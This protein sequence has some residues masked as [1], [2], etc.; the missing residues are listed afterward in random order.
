[1]RLSLG[2]G[3]FLA[4]VL[5]AC[6]TR[7]YSVSH[8]SDRA[9]YRNPAAINPHDMDVSS[10]QATDSSSKK[11]VLSGTKAWKE[12]GSVA[13]RLGHFIAKSLSGES[14]K[15]CDVFH[16]IALTFAAE[17][18]ATSG[19][20]PTMLIESACVASKDG[21]TTETI[22]IPV[23]QIK[24]EKP[25]DSEL[26]FTTPTDVV[27]KLKDIPGEWPTYWVLKEIKLIDKKE[28]RSMTIDTPTIYRLSQIPISISWN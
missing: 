5:G 12:N 4:V 3:V 14:S 19:A 26:R 2:F 7:F 1:M 13:I 11:R 9:G 20:R 6:L 28:G 27:V 21:N 25:A 10:D 23:D 17:G 18:M 22:W 24:G 16:D 15:L 8:F